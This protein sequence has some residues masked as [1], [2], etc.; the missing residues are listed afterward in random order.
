MHTT[1]IVSE[2]DSFTHPE[3]MAHRYVCFCGASGPW[4]ASMF[5]AEEDATAHADAQ[6]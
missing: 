6:A 5:E 4:R 2:Q 3:I 1:E